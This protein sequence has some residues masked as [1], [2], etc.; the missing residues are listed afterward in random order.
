MPFKSL[1][2]WLNFI[3]S[4]RPKKEDFGLDR[5]KGLF[6]EIV[7]SKVAD[8]TFVIGG[9]NGKGSA[10]EFLTNLFINSNKTVGTYTSPHIL[11]Y[12]ERIRINSLSVSD[13]AISAAFEKIYKLKGDI[14]LT[15]F[16]YSTLAAMLIF[17]ENGV[18]VGIFEV[19]LGGRL[20]PVN[21]LDADFSLITNVELDH[22]K[23]L[24]NSKEEIG[25]EKAAIIRSDNTTILGQKD[26]PESVVS[27]ANLLGTKLIKVEKDYSFQKL[28]ENL[29]NY[30]LEMPGK[31]VEINKISQNNL[32]IESASIALTAYF[33]SSGVNS[34]NIKEVVERTNLLGRCFYVGNVILDVAHNP[35][36]VEKLK[37]FLFKTKKQYSKTIAYAGFMRDKDVVSM[38][39]ALSDQVD[40]WHVFDLPLDR[41][42]KAKEVAEIIINVTGK[43]PFV[44][45]SILEA[46]HLNYK[47][48]NDNLNVVFGSFHTVCEACYEL[49]SFG[50]KI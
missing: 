25:K 29:W 16:D 6:N 1:E 44:H 7:K 2:E 49:E 45:E 23:W 39:K 38:I 9:T 27:H 22:Q 20:D 36:S 8:T 41:A 34:V 17:L 5:I 24:G 28:N 4:D 14:K 40:D 43:K 15:Y 35:S 12:N 46:F 3:D 37:A 26:I 18:E 48:D 33:L 47:I 13:K 21:L 32:S 31:K 11:K 10:A 19:G 42:M 30:C 50:L